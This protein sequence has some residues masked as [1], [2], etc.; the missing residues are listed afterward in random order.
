[1]SETNNA[2]SGRLKRQ[3]P[4]VMTKPPVRHAVDVPQN[5]P[6]S[7]AAIVGPIVFDLIRR[8]LSF[9]VEYK[10]MGHTIREVISVSDMPKRVEIEEQGHVSVRIVPSEDFSALWA[11]IGPGIVTELMKL[12][13]NDIRQKAKKFL[14]ANNPQNANKGA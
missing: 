6:Y 1:M 3:P 7:E 14:T 12:V 4:S 5:S 13:H 8:V 2:A 9:G 11:V 10:L